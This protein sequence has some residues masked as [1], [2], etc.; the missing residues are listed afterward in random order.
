MAY[1]FCATPAAGTQE[2]DIERQRRRMAHL[3]CRT[4]VVD[5]DRW[6]RVFDSHAEAQREA[7]LTLRNVWRNVDD[8]NDVFAFFEV[9]DMEKARGFV[10]SP[11][12]PDAQLDSG[13]VGEADVVFLK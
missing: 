5:Y 6:K 13:V 7:G 9:D 11:E 2:I 10:T 3:I 1:A 12:V 4:R 8:P